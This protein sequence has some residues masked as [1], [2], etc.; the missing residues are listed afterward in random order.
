M[1][2]RTVIMSVVNNGTATA[3]TAAT[4]A[5]RGCIWTYKYAGR[6]LKSATR[7]LPVGSDIRT[8]IH[9]QAD[10]REELSDY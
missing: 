6:G 10:V 3:T 5:H 2:K 8:D 1:M 4:I 9:A 7:G